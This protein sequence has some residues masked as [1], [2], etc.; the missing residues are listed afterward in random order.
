MFVK[1][2][3]GYIKC[4]GQGSSTARFVLRSTGRNMTGKHLAHIITSIKMRRIRY[5]MHAAG[6]SWLRVNG[7]AVSLIQKERAGLL[8]DRLC[9]EV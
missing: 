3:V 1:C 2:A 5:A 7:A 9:E 4:V 8:Y 6:L